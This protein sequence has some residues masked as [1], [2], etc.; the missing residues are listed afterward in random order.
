V[1]AAAP[2]LAAEVRAAPR[3]FVYAAVGA[4]AL[5]VGL[6]GGR[7][8]MAVYGAPLLLLVVA[9]V[10]V[11][12]RAHVALKAEFEPERVVH[13]DELALRVRGRIAPPVSRLDV[14]ALRRGPID[15]HGPGDALGAALVLAGGID[16][17]VPVAT[18]G[19]GLARVDR[20]DVRADS[21]LG[22]VRQ[23][24]SLPVAATARVLPRPE[25][26]RELLHPAP[27]AIA[28]IHPSAARGTGTDFAELRPVA[29]GDRL[30]DVNWL[31]SARRARGPYPRR[32][33]AD[34]VVSVRHPERTGDVVLLLDTLA[35]D[36]VDAAP[37]LPTAA[38]AAWSVARAHLAA[39]DRVGVV[40]LGG[41]PRWVAPSVGRAARYAVLDALL[42]AQASWSAV[43][44]TLTGTPVHLL[45]P[46]AL[47]V[48]I[49][50]LH[51]PRFAAAAIDL[52]RQGRDVAVVALDASA[53]LPPLTGTQALAGRL[54][55]L[56]LENRIADLERAGVPVARW[57]A[58]AAR[59]RADHGTAA[60]AG[61][62]AAV[63]LLRR[64]RRAPLRV[65]Q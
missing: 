33:T 59:A 18:T 44:R 27:R 9:A 5:L 21:P 32:T 31:A 54:W 38:A 26:L 28:G 8:G 60:T 7:P 1:S 49:S 19:W 61:V 13:G 30:A 22:L 15:P 41:Y 47:V 51:D 36:R 17:A 53:W 39:H 55:T 48:A 2:E 20:V 57:Q 23:E 34:L 24:W 58:R 14:L 43:D 56:A 50:P 3:L 35:D 63:A 52:R 11:S 62:A 12:R 10:L 46:G 4:G 45:P 29:P 16:T 6:A 65:R 42:S 25:R 40:A 64:R 37:W